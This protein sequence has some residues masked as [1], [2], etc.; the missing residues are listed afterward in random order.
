MHLPG[1]LLCNKIIIMDCLRYSTGIG[2]CPGVSVQGTV[3][4]QVCVLGV[5]ERCEP[6]GVEQ[7]CVLGGET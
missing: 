6:S 1:G 2:V 3:G 5:P 4:V 7:V